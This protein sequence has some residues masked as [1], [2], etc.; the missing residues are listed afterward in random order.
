MGDENKCLLHSGFEAR[1]S[2]LCRKIEE[3]ENLTSVKL[4][5]MEKALQ[6]AY[7]EMERRI[8]GMNEFRAQ[9]SSQGSTF[10]T[11]NE[12]ELFKTSI[13]F[14]ITAIE[15]T[16]FYKEGAGKWTS[17]IITVLIA[18]AIFIMSHYLFKI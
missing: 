10:F 15:K 9:L 6:V 17:H 3:K 7:R 18:L 1:I 4:E 12:H 13:E 8:E 11:K 5:A 16:L 2:S 14:R